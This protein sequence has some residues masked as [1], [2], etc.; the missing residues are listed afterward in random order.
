MSYLVCVSVEQL[1]VIKGDVNWLRISN[2]YYLDKIQFA[3]QSATMR[4]HATHTGQMILKFVRYFQ[5]FQRF[6]FVLQ[7]VIRSKHVQV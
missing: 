6:L 4:S 1:S 3:N 2:E 5:S 7:R